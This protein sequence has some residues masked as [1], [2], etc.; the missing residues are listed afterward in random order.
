MSESV[1]IGCNWMEGNAFSNAVC[2]NELIL[3][4]RI[5]KPYSN[6]SSYVI[7]TYQGNLLEGLDETRFEVTS[8]ATSLTVSIH[9]VPYGNHS[10]VCRT[11][12]NSFA[13]TRLYVA[14]KIIFLSSKMHNNFVQVSMRYYYNYDSD[15]PV[16]HLQRG[17]K[18]TKPHTFVHIFAK[19]WPILKFFHRN[20]LWKICN[21]LVTKYT[22]TP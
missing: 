22:T 10:L 5:Y 13:V 18:N 3:N 20:I 12:N 4:C 6:D 14:G 17:P 11:K 1:D 21:K 15:D 8:D 16:C 9:D 19:Y 7:L 2:I